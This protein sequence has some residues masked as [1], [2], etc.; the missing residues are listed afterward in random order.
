MGQG[1]NRQIRQADSAPTPL[2]LRVL[3]SGPLAS[4]FDRSVDIRMPTGQVNI[5]PRQSENLAA[6]HPRSQC[7]QY[8]NVEAGSNRC[9]DQCRRPIFVNGREMD[10][11]VVSNV[12]AGSVQILINGRR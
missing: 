11:A 8:R 1:L 9:L 7:H 3:Y 5:G 12:L 2:G 10:L 6:A 4:L